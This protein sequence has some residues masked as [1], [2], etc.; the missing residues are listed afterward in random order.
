MCYF[1]LSFNTPILNTNLNSLGYKPEFISMIITVMSIAY[2]IG[3]PAVTHLTAKVNNRAILFVGIVFA[4]VG[5]LMTGITNLKEGHHTSAFV[6]LGIIIFGFG[7]AMLTIPVM[8]E[9][10][11]AIEETYNE[12]EYDDQ[13]LYNHLAGY[14][15]FGQAL[16]ESLGPALSSLL[17]ARFDYTSTQLILA[18]FVA[19]FL[20]VYLA[21]CD[22]RTFFSLRLQPS[23]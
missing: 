20:V 9:I 22:Y 1:I 4:Q 6:I 3:I 21:L 7:F 11:E 19:V 17:N 23:K 12:G 5:M 15:V 13:T 16:G 10:L 2:A 8:P 14:F 18:A